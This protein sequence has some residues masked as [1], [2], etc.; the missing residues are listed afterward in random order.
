MYVN[1]GQFKIKVSPTGFNGIKPADLEQFHLKSQ[2]TTK[3]SDTI[4]NSQ[5]IISHLH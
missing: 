2:P 5:G 4:F 1:I 3:S